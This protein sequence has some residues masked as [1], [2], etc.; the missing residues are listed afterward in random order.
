MGLKCAMCVRCK[1]WGPQAGKEAGRAAAAGRSA[2]SLAARWCVDAGR[3][4]TERCERHSKGKCLQGGGPA[5]AHGCM[6]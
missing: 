5:Y 2:V 3:A 6:G 1:D 4:S